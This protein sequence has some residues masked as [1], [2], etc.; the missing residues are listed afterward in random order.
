VK[1]TKKA[2]ATEKALLKRYKDAD[3]KGKAVMRAA[4]DVLA[5]KLFKLNTRMAT[6][7]KNYRVHLGR[8]FGHTQNVVR[9]ALEAAGIKVDQRPI[10]RYASGEPLTVNVAVKEC[11]YLMEDRL[12]K[13][14]NKT[15]FVSGLLN[16][17]QALKAPATV[18]L[19][20][21]KV[22]TVSELPVQVAQD[23][24]S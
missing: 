18:V 20:K 9:G 15:A 21:K 10:A 4:A 14:A 16:V 11:R 7:A 22:T 2:S 12:N 13:V 8:K 6:I 24:A 5:V 3:S 23:L 19:K 1:K 17:V